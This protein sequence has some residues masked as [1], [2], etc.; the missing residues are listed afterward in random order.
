MSAGFAEFGGT[1]G[2]LGVA[3]MVLRPGRRE[4]IAGLGAWAIGSGMLVLYLAPAG[5]HRAYAAAAVV[6]AIVA[7]LLAWVYVRQI[8]RA[9]V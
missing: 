6:G 2:A 3:L 7:A 9:H 1:I 5:H 8:G 4:R